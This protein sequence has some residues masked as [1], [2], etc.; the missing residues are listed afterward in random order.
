MI[1]QT[2]A[3]P[4][5]EP[6][7]RV[8]IGVA[9]RVGRFDSRQGI[10]IAPPG[11]GNWDRL[12]RHLA[13]PITITRA[14]A[15]FAITDRQGQTI[16][17]QVPRLM[18]MGAGGE[19]IRVDQTPYPQTIVL[20][21]QAD[22]FDV[23]NHVKMESYLPGVLQKELFGHWHPTAFRAQAIAA[24]TYAMQNG[25]RTGKRHFDL[26]STTAS[27]VYA[28]ASAGRRAKE[29]VQRTRGAVLLHNRRVFPAYYS[30]S[31]GGVGQDAAAAFPNSLDIPPLRG[32]KRHGWCKASKYYRWGPIRRDAANLSR[33]IAAWGVRHKHAVASLSGIVSVQ[34]ARSNRAGRPG[35]FAVTDYS[36]RTFTLDAE[37]L[38][39]ACN[40]DAPA[41]PQLAAQHI[42]RSS[43]VQAQVQGNVITFYGGQGFG[44]GVGMCQWGAQGM[45]ERG[46]D[47]LKILATYYPGAEVRRLY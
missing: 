38:R 11:E 44:H 31:C 20:H 17:W 19:S 14:G 33:R 18:M 35:R 5:A 2:G 3:L 42:L 13:S 41:L 47:E 1:S 7:V 6:T 10:W 4:A 36:G 16:R 22:G 29:A 43:H 40:F 8:R 15:Q 27:Q 12:R 45:A 24:R 21:A 23:V 25:R 9:M 37:Q 46:Y 26:E 28:G 30:S 32:A 34:I 39:F